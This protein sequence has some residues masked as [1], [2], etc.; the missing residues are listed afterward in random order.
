VVLGCEFYATGEKNCVI[1]NIVE[2]YE[3]DAPS[4]MRKMTHTLMVIHDQVLDALRTGKADSV[5]DVGSLREDLAKYRNLM[6][7]MLVG[8]GHS[9]PVSIPY[10][11]VAFYLSSA[12]GIYRELYSYLA[13]HKQTI[14]PVDVKLLED[15]G[16]Y[17]RDLMTLKSTP[18]ELHERYYALDKKVLSVDCGNL[19]AYELAILRIMFSTETLLL[20]IRELEKTQK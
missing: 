18:R 2:R 19:K 8:K 3:F 12:G 14:K 6:G 9:Q 17:L 16:K 15:I 7:R 4:L 13:E 11:M 5:E 10:L 1:R 20:E